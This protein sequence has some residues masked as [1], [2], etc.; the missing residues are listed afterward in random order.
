MLTIIYKGKTYYIS[1][2]PL[3]RVDIDA[4]ERIE[5]KHEQLQAELDKY[6]DT[7]LTMHGSIR[8][9]GD[10][11]RDLCKMVKDKETELNDLKSGHFCLSPQMAKMATLCDCAHSDRHRA[12]DWATIDELQA[13]L[14]K[15]Q[16]KN[17]KQRIEIEFLNAQLSKYLNE[18]KTH[19]TTSLA[20]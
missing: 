20:K 13:E 15:Y 14:D 8:N 11:N 19:T 6:K 3:A 16:A 10:E 7:I 2:G 1:E 17:G 4:Y 9:L 18:P 5:K 12:T